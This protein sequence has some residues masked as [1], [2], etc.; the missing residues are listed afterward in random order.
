MC[1]NEAYVWRIA[2]IYLGGR[3]GGVVELKEVSK[4][5]F[6]QKIYRILEVRL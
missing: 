6:I 2:N 4:G 3:G 1:I 5:I